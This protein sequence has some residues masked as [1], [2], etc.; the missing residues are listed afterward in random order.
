M[1][2]LGY[3]DY[4][5]L[6]RIDDND[7]W[8]VCRLNADANP[9]VIDEPRTVRG[10]SIDLEGTHLKEKPQLQMFEEYGCLCLQSFQHVRDRIL[11][12]QRSG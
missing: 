5:R 11:V 7:G 3:L 4:G 2:D 6:G 10:N 8:F 12:W 1:F 9:H